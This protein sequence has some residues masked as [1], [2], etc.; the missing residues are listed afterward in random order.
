MASK[1]RSTI[2]D[3][4]DI[5]SKRVAVPAWGCELEIRSLTGAQRATA[6]ERATV[7]TTDAEGKEESHVDSRILNPLLLIASCYDPESG[8]KVFEDADA[9]G[10]ENKSAEALD[11][12][13][14]EILTL[15]GMTKAENKALEKNSGAT[16]TAAGASV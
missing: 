7:K 5:K 10:I 16:A 9:E 6:V 1:L 13:T 2:L 15:N 11:I 8:E 4:K 12:V 3:A 14:T